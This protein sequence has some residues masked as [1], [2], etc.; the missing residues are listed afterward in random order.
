MDRV[1]PVT[2]GHI[3]AK[4]KYQH[5]TYCYGGLNY[6]THYITI[7]NHDYP[8]SEKHILKVYLGEKNKDY[9]QLTIVVFCTER[10]S[11]AATNLLPAGKPVTMVSAFFRS[12]G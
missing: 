9:N 12:A 8:L 3:T 4:D 5:R 10:A 7:N 2:C 11:S 1:L 6:F